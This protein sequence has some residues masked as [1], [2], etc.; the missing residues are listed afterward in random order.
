MK[1]LL[2]IGVILIFIGVTSVFAQRK[3]VSGAEVTGTFRMNFTGKF[4]GNS[5][6]I[7]I[8]ALGDGKLGISMS[9]IYPYEYEKGKMT[10]N[11]GEA[12]GTATIKG[13]TAIFTPE[14]TDTCK[15]TIKFVK[16]GIIKV[17][18][19]GGENGCG[20]G[21][22]VYSDGTYK[23]ITSRKPKLKT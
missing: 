6:E 17:T 3:S 15:I 22:N 7:K 20:F 13:D 18:E 4:K 12:D 2:F 14:G 8:A 11:T 10:A 1:K 21:H 9:L 5:N 23:K 16:A 19:D